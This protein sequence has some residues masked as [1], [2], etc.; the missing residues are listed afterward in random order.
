M[1][2]DFHDES[3]LNYWGSSKFSD[4]IG[5]FL[6]SFEG[7]E[8]NRTTAGYE[9]WDENARLIQQELESF[10]NG[11]LVNCLSFRKMLFQND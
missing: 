6:M 9:S 7:V 4:Y 5:D 2:E 11:T 3:H 8:D 10:E 1:E